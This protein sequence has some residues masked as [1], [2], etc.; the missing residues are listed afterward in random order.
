MLETLNYLTCDICKKKVKQEDS[1][2]WYKIEAK[3][4]MIHAEARK[5]VLWSQ[6]VDKD[7][8][9]CSGECLRKEIRILTE[10]PY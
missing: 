3:S 2:G 5:D 7:R 1:F 6:M 4:F 8:H 10:L 9:Y